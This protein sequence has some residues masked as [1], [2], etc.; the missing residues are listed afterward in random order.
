[1]VGL[2]LSCLSSCQLAEDLDDYE[3]L[4]ALDANK[5]KIAAHKVFTLLDRTSPVDPI[6][7]T[8]TVVAINET[9]GSSKPHPAGHDL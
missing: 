4:N 6:N 5:A 2:G 1:M 9:H 8:G 7:P 3:P